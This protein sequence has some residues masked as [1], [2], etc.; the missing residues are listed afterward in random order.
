[1]EST[2]SQYRCENRINGTVVPLA[3]SLWLDLEGGTVLVGQEEVMLTA[4]EVK[5]LNLLVNVS[6]SSRCYLTAY[7]IAQRIGLADTFDAEHCIEQTIS[8]LRR[9]FG[10]TPHHPC[11]LKGRR[12][13]G[14][15]LFIYTGNAET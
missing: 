13:L 6:R 14:Y 5:I 11:I 12:G 9:K 7:T 1:M 10:E 4:R 15:R 8:M 3:E 2:S